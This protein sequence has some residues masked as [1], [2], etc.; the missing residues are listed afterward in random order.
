VRSF[1]IFKSFVFIFIAVEQGGCQ[2][3]ITKN[4]VAENA[5]V[6]AGFCCGLCFAFTTK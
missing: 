6:E 2:W 3:V 5:G 1:L 4:Y